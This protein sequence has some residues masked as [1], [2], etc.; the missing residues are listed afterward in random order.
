MIYYVYKI[1]L[2]KGSLSGKYYIGQHRTKNINDGYAGSGTILRNYYKACGKKEGE[3][4]IKEILQY[5]SSIAELNKVENELISDRYSSDPNCINLIAGGNG[6][7]Y[8]EE[9]RRKI[10]EANK[11]REVSEEQRK[12]ISASLMGHQVPQE[13]RALISKRVKEKCKSPEYCKK[14]SEAQKHRKPITEETRR[15]IAEAGKGRIGCWAGKKMPKSITEK[16]SASHKGKIVINNGVDLKRVKPSELDKYL[17]DGW[18]RG[19][20]ESDKVAMSERNKGK[21]ITEE[22][23]KKLSAINKGRRMTEEARAKVAANNRARANDPVIRKK[24]SDAKKGK[25]HT[26]EHIA[27][28]AAAKR[29]VPQSEESKRK[30]SEAMKG[31]HWYYDKQLNK[32]VY[33][34][35]Q[36]N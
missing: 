31:K 23:K 2:L 8:S 27:K 26:P 29:G 1:T 5:C 33:Y 16:M 24:I 35:L 11:G 13:T 4:Y 34:V 25:P 36:G 17:A 32:R 28:V 20:R 21:T 6:R 9:T 10:S 12:L 15:K 18:V 7:G 22:T 3:T 19:M 14:I 30:R